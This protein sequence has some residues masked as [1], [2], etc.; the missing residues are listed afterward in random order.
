MF[1]MCHFPVSCGRFVVKITSFR[2]GT[3]KGGVPMRSDILVKM[4]R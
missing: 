1:R 3:I 2:E 4:K